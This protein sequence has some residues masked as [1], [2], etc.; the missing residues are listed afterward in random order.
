MPTGCTAAIADGIDFETFVMR[1]ARGMGALIMMRD[2][3]IDAPIPERFEP[4]DYHT[5]KLAE[6]NAELEK[7]HAMSLEET[8][9]AAREAFEAETK[10]NGEA[11]ARNRELRGKYEAMLSQVQAWE[12]PT[13]DHDSF[14]KFIADQLTESIRFDCSESYYEERK[15][16]Q[17]TGAEWLESQIAKAAQDVEYHTTEHAKEVERTEGRNGWIG[18]LRN[19]LSTH[20]LCIRHPKWGLVTPHFWCISPN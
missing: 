2:E 17:Q 14:K 9:A 1:C 8:E 15:P 11:I 5:R 19:S 7:L 12:P 13:P 10:A 16:K 18:A 6:A 20:K 4:S 3:P